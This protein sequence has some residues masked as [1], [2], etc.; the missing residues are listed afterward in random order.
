MPKRTVTLDTKFYTY[1]QNNSGGSYKNNDAGG[2]GPI[3]IVEA[4]SADDANRR[5]ENIGLYFDGY[6]DCECC[7][8]RWHVQSDENE[9][10]ETATIY[11]E[12]V[13]KGVYTSPWSNS[14]E[15]IEGYI[16]HFDGHITP[17]LRVKPKQNK[18]EE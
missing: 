9:G 4:T 11:D 18:S 16:H 3:V 7:G 15:G 17:I 6:G 2:I 14:S 8:N 13:S 12:D 10:K 1:H 5:A